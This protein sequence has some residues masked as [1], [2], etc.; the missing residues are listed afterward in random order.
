M[1]FYSLVAQDP[2]PL[3]DPGSAGSLAEVPS[4]PNGFDSLDPTQDSY[5]FD[6]RQM[7][8]KLGVDQFGRPLAVSSESIVPVT[9]CTSDHIPPFVS[10]EDNTS[11][12][13]FSSD[14]LLSP[15]N[16]LLYAFITGFTASLASSFEP[17]SSF[18]ECAFCGYW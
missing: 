6:L 1:S 10:E 2:S 17:T 5:E 3:V 11:I 9:E 8:A 12:T 14:K 4:A 13:S 15:D 18:G 7:C 16:P